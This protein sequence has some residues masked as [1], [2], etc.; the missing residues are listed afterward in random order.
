MDEIPYAGINQ[1]RFRVGDG[2]GHPLSLAPQAPRAQMR[3]PLHSFISASVS[4]LG[5]LVKC[6]SGA[7]GSA[8]LLQNAPEFRPDGILAALTPIL[9]YGPGL[10]A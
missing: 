4:P 3:N 2:Y 9:I 6:D 8:I 1:I 7:I 5:R 10:L